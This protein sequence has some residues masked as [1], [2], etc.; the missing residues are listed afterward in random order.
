[1]SL[2]R[3]VDNCFW[4]GDRTLR[5]ENIF[6]IEFPEEEKDFSYVTVTAKI[7]MD[8]NG[9]GHNRW[10]WQTFFDKYPSMEYF[11]QDN[12]SMFWK[13]Y[14][15]CLRPI[16]LHSKNPTFIIQKLVSLMHLNN[17]FRVKDLNPKDLQQTISAML[18]ILKLFALQPVHTLEKFHKCLESENV[19]TPRQMD[20]LKNRFN[21]LLKTYKQI[22]FHD[23]INL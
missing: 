16:V 8:K 22:E 23:E 13:D 12:C 3:E 4:K 19:F 21:E 18:D 10:R 17:F 1:M 5:V 9:K 6:D 7:V 15:K 2:S 20:M 11:S 14:V